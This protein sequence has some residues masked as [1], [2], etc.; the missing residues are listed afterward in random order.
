MGCGTWQPVE[1]MTHHPEAGQ[2][3]VM[4]SLLARNQQHEI[5]PGS[6]LRRSAHLCG[7]PIPR[8]GAGLRDAAAVHR[9]AAPHRRSVAHL[10]DAALLR[11]DERINRN[12]EVHPDHACGADDAPPGTGVVFVS[13]VPGM[14]GGICR[15][16]ARDH[17][18]RRRRAARHGPDCWVGVRPFVS[19]AATRR[20]EHGLSCRRRSRPFPTT[21]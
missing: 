12:A 7:I 11:A 20:A 1:R 8:A 19:I 4:H 6:R 10:R 18:R 3:K 2:A 5:R 9:R 16:R 17:G 14:S 13:A 21:S 15:T